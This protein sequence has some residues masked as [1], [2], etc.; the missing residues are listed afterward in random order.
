MAEFKYEIVEEIA[1]ISE[2]SRGWS[3][4]LNLISWNERSPKYDLRE[5]SPEH[6]KMGKG[7]TLSAEELKILRDALN[8]LEL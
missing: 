6:E 2:S 1:V 7:I 8:K 3:K 5:W 4:E